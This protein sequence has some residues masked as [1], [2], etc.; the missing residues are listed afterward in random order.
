[1]IDYRH[2]GVD[3]IRIHL[4]AKTELGQKLSEFYIR[5]F[6]VE[7]YAEFNHLIGFSLYL[8]TGC[9]HSK[10]RHLPPK[11]CL[12]QSRRVRGIWRDDFEVEYSKG[13]VASLITDP[14]LVR[15]LKTSTLP[16]LIYN[17]KPG[18]VIGHKALVS[19]FYESYRQLLNIQS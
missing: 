9:K 2:D 17:R 18:D 19:R 10:F 8:R 12:E 11:D 14:E 7:G 1:M 5:P 4:D 13:I 16:L 6:V 15:E 3:H